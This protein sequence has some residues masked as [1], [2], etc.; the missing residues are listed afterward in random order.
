MIDNFICRDCQCGNV[1]QVKNNVL[2]KFDEDQKKQLGVDITIDSCKNFT[3][4]TNVD[5]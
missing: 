1:C 3:P 2:L 4:S 5:T